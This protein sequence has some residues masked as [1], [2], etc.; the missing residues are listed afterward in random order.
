VL[1]RS[2]IDSVSSQILCQ[3]KID[4][5]H[6]S[7]ARRSSPTL[8]EQSII[9][10][11]EHVGCGFHKGDV[12]GIGN[13]KS[14]GV[15]PL[16][17][18]PHGTKI[19]RGVSAIAVQEGSDF[20]PLTCL[21]NGGDFPEV[22]RRDDHSIPAILYVLQDQIKSVGLKTDPHEILVIVGST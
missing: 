6:G 16:H 7:H 11:N 2:K 21:F 22:Y 17:P 1:P 15:Q 4:G 9:T 19:R 13:A 5:T 14:W 3:A 12:R 8:P 20:C 18:F 10:R